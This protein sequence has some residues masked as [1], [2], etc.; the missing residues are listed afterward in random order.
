VQQQDQ[1]G[2]FAR[3]LQQL[4]ME[5][6]EVSFAEIAARISANREARGAPPAAARVARSTVYDAFR[7]DRSR[8]D[9]ELVADIVEALGASDEERERW[10]RDALG[11]RPVEPV[12]EPVEITPVLRDDRPGWRWPAA[13]PVPLPAGMLALLVVASI[14][15]NFFGDSVTDSFHMTIWLDTVGTA[16]VAL[17]VGPWA[18]A[19]VAAGTMLLGA[20]P[21]G[22]D[23]LWYGLVAVSAALVWGHGARRW[24]LLRSPLRFLLLSTI[25]ALV[26]TCVSVPITVLVYGGEPQHGY[27][28]Y[29]QMLAEQGEQLWLALGTANLLAS[30][31]DKVLSGFL[32][33]LALAV[34]EPRIAR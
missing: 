3:R 5:A 14:G 28:V 7:S 15:L 27:E 19:A 20:V 2:R 10:R 29:L 21:D 13:F 32:A 1:R 22:P 6:G 34:L 26:C 17:R 9:A 12:P 8:L 18:G 24:G 4:R 11:L 30:V 31:T 23:Y 33:V 16:I 25:V